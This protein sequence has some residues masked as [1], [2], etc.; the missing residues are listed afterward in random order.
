MHEQSLIVDKS[1]ITKQYNYVEKKVY[2][3]GSSL[4]KKLNS[5]N[6]N[7]RLIDYKVREQKNSVTL[8]IS[9]KYKQFR[10]LVKKVVD[11]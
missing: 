4:N 11:K 2:L 7:T 6:T 10:Y 1:N 8:E 5:I 9:Y 3:K